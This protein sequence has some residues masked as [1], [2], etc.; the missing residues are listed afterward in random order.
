[1]YCSRFIT[2]YG[3]VTVYATAEGVV[4]VEIPDMSRPET[5]LQRV[6]P[7]FEPSEIT[8]HAA[9]SLQRYFNGERVEFNDIPVLLDGI[10][11]FRQKVLNELR[12][13][14][15]GEIC[16]YGQLAE[17]CGSPHAARA[18]GGALAA[19]P[20]PVIIPCHRVVASNGCLTGYSAPGGEGTKRALLK[21]EGVEFSGLQVVTNQLVMHRIPGR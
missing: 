7:E 10:T 2:M 5:A 16:S 4:K 14:S 12:S 9:Q 20:V 1:M 13:L 21:M 18:I 17:L 11:P 6:L 19:N 8:I 3:N 15:F